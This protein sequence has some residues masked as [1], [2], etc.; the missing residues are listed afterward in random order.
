[1]GGAPEVLPKR[2]G[3]SSL[4]PRPCPSSEPGLQVHNAVGPPAGTLTGLVMCHLPWE[5]LWD[6]HRAL[7]LVL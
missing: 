4:A 1:M 7:F 5:M 2:H 6:K 3:S